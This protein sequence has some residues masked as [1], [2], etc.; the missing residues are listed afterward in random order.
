VLGRPLP[1]LKQF[2]YKFSSTVGVQWD[3]GMEDYEKWLTKH[4]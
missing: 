1:W 4:Q 2:Q 3:W